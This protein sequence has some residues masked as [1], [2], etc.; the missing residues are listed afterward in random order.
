MCQK[1]ALSIGLTKPILHMECS[2]ACAGGDEKLKSASQG[3]L[4][5]LGKRLQRAIRHVHENHFLIFCQRLFLP[6]DPAAGDALG[7]SPASKCCVLL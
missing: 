4:I 2:D 7:V 1:R 6:L 5:L 3:A